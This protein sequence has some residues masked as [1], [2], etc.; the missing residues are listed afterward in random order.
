M[1]KKNYL[2]FKFLSIDVDVCLCSILWFGFFKILIWMQM[3]ECGRLL[4]I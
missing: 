1:G 4:V 2:I 3:E